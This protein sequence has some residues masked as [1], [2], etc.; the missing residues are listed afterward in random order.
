MPMSSITINFQNATLTFVNTTITITDGNF[1]LDTMSALSISGTIAFDSLYLTSNA[2]NFNVETGTTFNAQVAV[3]VSASS[4]APSIEI[5]NFAGT[6]TV[7]W[8]TATGL[9]TQVIM[10]DSPLTLNGFVD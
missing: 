1:E 6:V 3:P 8:P 2:I 4:G 9:E 10:P 5:T 7:T